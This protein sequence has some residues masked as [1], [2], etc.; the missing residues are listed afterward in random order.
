MTREKLL[1]LPVFGFETASLSLPFALSG[2]A[3]V[4]KSKMVEMPGIE[5]G[6]N[7]LQYVFVL[8]WI[9]HF[10][11]ALRNIQRKAGEG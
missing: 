1:Y 8:L 9:F 10:S 4:S 11:Q 2:M 6:S 3:G 5:P 7:V